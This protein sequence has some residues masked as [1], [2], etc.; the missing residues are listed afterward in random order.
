MG[1]RHA[2]YCLLG[3]MISCRAS[4]AGVSPS[5]VSAYAMACSKVIACPSDHA[6]TASS[7]LHAD[8]TNSSV[9]SS[10]AYKLGASGVPCFCR[11]AA[12]APAR[13]RARRG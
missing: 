10:L 13:R 11:S 3:Q 5:T 8:R 7:P 1:F 9:C 12:A 2:L 4:A 6:T